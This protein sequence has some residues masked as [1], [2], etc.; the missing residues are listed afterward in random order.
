MDGVHRHLRA[1]ATAP[2]RGVDFEV[3]RGSYEA[4]TFGRFNNAVFRQWWL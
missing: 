3:H 1:Q 4:L 2:E